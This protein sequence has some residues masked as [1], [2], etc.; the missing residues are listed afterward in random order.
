MNPSLE[1]CRG[2]EKVSAAYPPLKN[3]PAR[4][5]TFSA[6]WVREVYPGQYRRQRACWARVKA[7]YRRTL[8][9]MHTIAGL[10]QA[11][12]FGMKQCRI[13]PVKRGGHRDQRKAF[14]RQP[15]MLRRSRHGMKAG[16]FAHRWPLPG[17]AWRRWAPR[18]T[19]HSPG[20]KA[21]PTGCPSRRPYPLSGFP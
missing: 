4:A 15:R 8:A 2:K 5:C 18:R 6:P 13:Q 9:R 10:H 17:P 19:S 7:S 16:G 14:R 1:Y 3:A 20:L 21:P 12:A 11:A